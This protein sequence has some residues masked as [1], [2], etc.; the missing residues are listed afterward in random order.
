MRGARALSP[1]FPARPSLRSTVFVTTAE[2]KHWPSPVCHHFVAVFFLTCA[3]TFCGMSS[4]AGSAFP[5]LFRC[6]L[7][8][9]VRLLAA[10]NIAS[11]R[12]LTF[13]LRFLP[14]LRAF[15]PWHFLPLPALLSRTCFAAGCLAQPA[16]W[17]RRR[18]VGPERRHVVCLFLLV[19]HMR[20][21]PQAFSCLAGCDIPET[22]PLQIVRRTAP[23]CCPKDA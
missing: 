4:L 21:R 18:R 7:L 17:P 1:D 9:A 12:A 13:R 3:G 8:G 5:Q 15:G 16:C 2:S 22:S 14:A 11:P 23:D 6:T 19:C 20:G 10:P